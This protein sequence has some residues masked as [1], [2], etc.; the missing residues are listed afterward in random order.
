MSGEDEKGAVTLVDRILARAVKEGAS[1]VHLE[2][3]SAG[4]RV[5]FRIDGVL[6]ERPAIPLAYRSSVV[7]RLKIMAKLDISEKRLPQDG[8]FRVEVGPREVDIRVATFPTEHGDKVSSESSRARRTASTST[9]SGWARRSR[10]SSR[11]R[12][13]APTGWSS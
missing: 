4:V 13:T 6:V 9:R 2:P 5:R 7:S 12:C 11:P 1:D 3:G 10:P 8:A